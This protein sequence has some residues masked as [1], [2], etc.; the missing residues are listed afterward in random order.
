MTR[1]PPVTGPYTDHRGEPI[2]EQCGG[3]KSAKQHQMPEVP[4]EVIE[5]EARRMG[6]AE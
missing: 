5:H 4:A 3:L 6:E 2:C 1:H